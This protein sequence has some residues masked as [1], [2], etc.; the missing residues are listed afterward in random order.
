MEDYCPGHK[1]WQPS[2]PAV[3]LLTN[4]MSAVFSGKSKKLF[5]RS[6]YIYSR[7]LFVFT[8][9]LEEKIHRNSLHSKEM[10][11]EMAQIYATEFVLL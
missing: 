7:R 1:S 9:T 10:R 11:S 6:Q 4:I 3:L 2:N 5:F 8:S